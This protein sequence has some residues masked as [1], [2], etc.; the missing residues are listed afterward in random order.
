MFLNTPTKTRILVNMALSQLGFAAIS[1]VAILSDHAM[2]AIIAVNVAFAIVIAYTNYAAMN[3]IVGGIARVKEYM[4]DLMEFVFYRKNKVRKAV[5]IKND[6]IGLILRELNEYADKFNDMRNN[7][8]HVLGEVVIA[9]DKVSQGIYN[10]RIHSDSNNFM[11]H[12]LK[13]VVNQMLDTTDHNMAKLVQIVEEYTNSDYRNQMD[14]NPILKGK[15]KLTLER[16]NQLGRELNENAR[17]NL[18]NGELLEYNSTTMNQSVENLASK[19]NEQAASL[20][21]T[22]A[23]V[24]EITSITKNNAQNASKMANLSEVVRESVLEGEKLAT[25]TANS[26]DEINEQVTAI[27]EAISVIDQIA[28][29]TNILSLN[30]A[31]EAATAGEAGKGFAVVAQEVRNLASRSAEAAK[32]IKEIVENATLK[33]N[34]GKGISDEMSQGY[35]NLNKLITQTIDLIK[36]VSNSSKEQLTGIEQINDAVTMLDRVTQDNAHEANNVSS[37]AQETLEMA[38]LLVADA[39]SKKI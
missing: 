20:E 13:K 33:T 21:Q 8:M 26:M 4:E 38:N 23:A 19:A 2:G 29:Q 3:R 10:T 1:I 32:E 31:V 17:K 9:L 12:A 36:D 25:K 16:I 34:E 28:F 15:M 18:K 37:I 27:N 22:A 7:D 24:E 11:I 39:K 30:A 6:D 5:Y 35:E 14:I